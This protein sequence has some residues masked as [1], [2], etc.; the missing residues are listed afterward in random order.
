MGT[1]TPDAEYMVYGIWGR[2]RPLDST[3]WGLFVWFTVFNY[4]PR[5][6]DAVVL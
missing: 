6:A 3:I 5:H 4:A 1:A 2:T